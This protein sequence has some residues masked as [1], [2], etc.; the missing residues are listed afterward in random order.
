MM[1][2]EQPCY[3]SLIVTNIIVSLTEPNLNVF[4]HDSGL[5]WI[6]RNLLA[7]MIFGLN[8][9]S[10]AFLIICKNNFSPCCFDWLVFLQLNCERKWL[11]EIQILPYIWFK[12][13]FGHTV[14]PVYLE[15]TVYTVNHRWS[16]TW[17][18][19]HFG[20]YYI[21]HIRIA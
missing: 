21:L 1:N 9:N 16:Q 8:I 5:F 6:S 12:P 11:N 14:I 4:G 20:I 15:K 7:C 18:D 13:Y 17:L 2:R 19:E 10:Q 3:L